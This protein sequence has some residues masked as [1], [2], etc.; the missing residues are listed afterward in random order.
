M[1]RAKISR[2]ERV[3][4]DQSS[5]NRQNEN[6]FHKMTCNGAILFDLMK[7]FTQ[8]EKINYIWCDG[9]STL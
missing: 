6:K 1:F 5:S 2:F 4:Q 9:R 3:Y 7:I 8:Y